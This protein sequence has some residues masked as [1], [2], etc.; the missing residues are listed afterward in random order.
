[1]KKGISILL[2]CFSCNCFGWN[3]LEAKWFKK[4]L[5]KDLRSVLV[6]QGIDLEDGAEDLIFEYKIYKKL[7]QDSLLDDLI[8]NAG[9]EPNEENRMIFFSAI[10]KDLR[11]HIKQSFIGFTGN[12]NQPFTKNY[13]NGSN[14][15]YVDP[16][17][18]YQ[19][20]MTRNLPAIIAAMGSKV[21]ESKSIDKIYLA[22]GA[23]FIYFVTKFGILGRGI[24][25]GYKYMQAK[26]NVN[27]FVSKT[28]EV[29]GNIWSKLSKFGRSVIRPFML[30]DYV[31]DYEESQE[32]FKFYKLFEEVLRDDRDF[33][34]NHAKNYTEI[35]VHYRDGRRKKRKFYRRNARL[36]LG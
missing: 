28:S 30:V 3:I 32:F 18:Y 16:N 36:G 24:K 1:M 11:D 7:I 19:A 15:N 35:I 20:E 33:V 5:A 9:L 12:N 23:A 31:D 2:F 13:P 22:L 17:F 4:E 29:T 27:S 14:F 26:E 6:K 8:K 10:S 25:I 34:Q 21:G